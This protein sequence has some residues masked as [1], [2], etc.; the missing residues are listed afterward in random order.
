MKRKMNAIPAL[1][2]E[3]DLSPIGDNRIVTTTR[4]VTQQIS[5]NSRSF[6]RPK[7]S[8]TAVPVSAPAKLVIEL[9]PKRVLLATAHT[10]PQ[11][12]L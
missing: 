6:L 11:G 3:D 5:A 4:Q 10:Q 8:T 9:E 2:R 1:A 12:L 7:R